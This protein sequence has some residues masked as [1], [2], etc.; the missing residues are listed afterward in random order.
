MAAERVERLAAHIAP[1]PVAATASSHP[2]TSAKKPKSDDDVVIVSAVRTPIARG[3]KGSFKNTVT[4]DLLTAVL[5]AVVEKVNVPK[6]AVQDIQVGNV[7]PLGGGALVA[8]QATFYAGFPHTTSLATLNRQCSSGLQAVANIVAA[9]RAGN[10]DVGIGAGVESMTLNYG[11]QTYPEK[12]SEKM[13]ENTLA[14]DCLVPMGIT[15]ENVAEAFKV[16]REKQVFFFF[17]PF[18]SVANEQVTTGQTGGCI[19]RQGHQ[20]AEGGQVCRDCPGD[21]QDHR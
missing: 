9:I 14:Q 8:R 4:E 5:K 17:F 7:L 12:M 6:S 13:N 11:P 20:G 15:S 10:I 19:A 16:D 3:H 21:G 2:V 1:A 18:C